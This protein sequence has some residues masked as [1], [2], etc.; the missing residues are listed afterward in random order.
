MDLLGVTG[1]PPTCD[2]RVDHGLSCLVP[3]SC[4]IYVYMVSA[5]F[6]DTDAE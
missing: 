2:V 5:L 4:T 3:P 1:V 6:R